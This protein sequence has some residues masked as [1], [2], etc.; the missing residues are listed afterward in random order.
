MLLIQNTF[1]ITYRGP[2]HTKGA[3]VGIIDTRFKQ[4]I[5][6]PWDYSHS[7]ELG[8]AEAYL[9]SIGYTD[10]IAGDLDDKS[11]IIMALKHKNA[12]GTLKPLKE[13]IKEA[14]G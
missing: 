1:K 8:V 7:D 10:L 14:R 4:G 13:A 6:I 9:K 12:D 5:V 3:R 11:Y 2:T